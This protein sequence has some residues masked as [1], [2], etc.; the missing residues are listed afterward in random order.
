MSMASNRSGRSRRGAT[1][2]DA[3]SSA[4][5]DELYQLRDKLE[6]QAQEIVASQLRQA[7]PPWRRPR[8]P[9]TPPKPAANDTMGSTHR[10]P[11]STTRQHPKR[12]ARTVR[13]KNKALRRPEAAPKPQKPKFEYW[14][15]PSE[16]AV[17]EPPPDSV[18]DSDRSHLEGLLRSGSNLSTTGDE[19]LFIILGLDFGTSSTKMIVRQA[20]EASEATI[21]IPAPVACRTSDN[22]YLWQTVI[23]LDEKGTFYAWPKSGATVLQSLKQGLI[24]G[25]SEAA[26]P[27]SAGA[28][29]VSR[30]QA[31]VAY[32]AFVIRYMRGWLLRNRPDLFRG[33][34]PVWFLN[35][36]MPAASYDDVKLAQPYRRIG[37]AALQLAKIDSPITAEAAQHFLDNPHVARAGT[38]ETAAEELGVAVLPEAAAEMTGFAKSTRTAPSLYLL[39]DVGAMTLDAC[40]FRLNQNTNLE[41]HFAFMEAQVRPLGVD[42]FHWFLAKGKT[43]REFVEQCDR[44][45]RS[46]V[47]KTKGHRDPK[48]ACW[49]PGNDVPVFLT[50][51]G[52]ASGL[53]RDIVVSI[54]PWLKHHVSNEGIQLLDLPVP[55]GIDLPEPLQDFGRMGV[56]WGL[57]YAPDQ[58]GHIEAMRDIDDIPRPVPNDLSKRFISKDQV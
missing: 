56:A 40:M 6:K 34:K 1:L 5:K 47:W 29:A 57:S 24:Q 19:E 53:H 35:L 23:W 45:L 9:A 43:E 46:V 30:A 49:T 39:V 26:L 54:G 32:L 3:L 2:G 27:R 41:D 8:M 17:R 7:P 20:F 58:I 50:G 44:T 16:A 52:A 48:A 18:L 51:G 14:A 25:R 37:A 13:S 36:G 31:G 12:R 33:R 15:F 55:S 42:A 11:I 21:A 4:V 10:A 28:V 38:S 22:A